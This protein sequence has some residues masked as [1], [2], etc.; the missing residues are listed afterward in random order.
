MYSRNMSKYLALATYLRQANLDQVTLS[1]D[2]IEQLC[3]PLPKSASKYQA[4]W[5]NEVEGSHVQKQGWRNAGYKVSS[6]KLG[7]WVTFTR[8]TW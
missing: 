5:S 4:W 2:D 6:Y 3:G 8:C 7:S 1:F